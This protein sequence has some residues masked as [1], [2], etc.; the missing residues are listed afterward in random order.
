M[1]RPHELARRLS[2]TAEVL[3][4]WHP[5]I[6]L[7]ELSIRNLATETSFRFEVAPENANDAFYHPYAYAV[8][9]TKTTGA[10]VLR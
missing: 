7:V 3:L 6:D 8:R 4:L 5:E 1:T 9:A 2:G 10:E